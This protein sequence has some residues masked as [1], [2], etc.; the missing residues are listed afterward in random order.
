MKLKLKNTLD[1]RMDMVYSHNFKI[2]GEKYICTSC[3]IW[4]Y[5]GSTVLEIITGKHFDYCKNIKMKNLLK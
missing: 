4:F 5:C 1:R 2:N 3:G